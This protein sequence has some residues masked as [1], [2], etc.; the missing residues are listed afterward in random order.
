MTIH[1]YFFGRN[2]RLINPEQSIIFNNKEQ[3]EKR[4]V[5]SVFSGLGLRACENAKT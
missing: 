2:Y 3:S 5:K 4:G 1:N